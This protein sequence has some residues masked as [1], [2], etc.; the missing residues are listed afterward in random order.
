MNR[1]PTEDTLR[2]IEAL[3]SYVGQKIIIVEYLIRNREGGGNNRHL[4]TRSQFTFVAD[5]FFGVTLSGLFLGLESENG[6]TVYTL[7]LYNVVSFTVQNDQLTIVEH[8]EAK[9]SRETVVR[10]AENRENCPSIFDP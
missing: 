4:A 6:A 9:T 5:R 8:M 7:S 10:S 2:L 1:L 3:Q